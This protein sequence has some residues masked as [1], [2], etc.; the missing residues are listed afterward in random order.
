MF[1]QKTYV[2]QARHGTQLMIALVNT[3]GLFTPL[4]WRF[5]GKEGNDE[6]KVRHLRRGQILRA[7]LRTTR[8]NVRVTLDSE[9]NDSCPRAENVRR[10]ITERAN[11]HEPLRRNPPGRDRPLREAE[12]RSM[13]QDDTRSDYRRGS[14]KFEPWQVAL[15]AVMAGSALTL[16]LIGILG[17]NPFEP[18]QVPAA[19]MAGAALTLAL[20]GILSHIR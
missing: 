18:W 15:A 8:R 7:V 16:S 20:I 3:S 9:Q 17:H 19:V 5:E 12:E 6:F 4:T 14:L 2:V 13:N 11:P 10:Q 1:L